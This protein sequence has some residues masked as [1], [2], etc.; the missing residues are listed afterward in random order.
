MIEDLF[1][2]LGNNIIWFIVWFY[3]VLDKFCFVIIEFFSLKFFDINIFD[4]N[5]FLNKSN[6]SW[7]DERRYEVVVLLFV[8][9]SVRF[10]KRDFRVFISL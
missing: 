10:E 1:L 8:I 5:V 2:F 6:F 7:G 9:F 3:G 4:S